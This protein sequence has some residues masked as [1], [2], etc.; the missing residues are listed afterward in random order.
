MI[1]IGRLAHA[2]RADQKIPKPAGETTGREFTCAEQQKCRR[3]A[4]YGQQ[5]E[6]EADKA[7]GS[8]HLSLA[9][10]RLVATGCDFS[11]RPI[12]HGRRDEVL[13]SCPD[14][15]LPVGSAFAR[16]VQDLRILVQISRR[17]VRT[18]T[19]RGS[20]NATTRRGSSAARNAGPAPAAHVRTLLGKRYRLCHNMAQRNRCACGMSLESAC[21]HKKRGIPCPIF[22]F[23]PPVSSFPKARW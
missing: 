16:H 3:D 14:D 23:S 13:S 4:E 22:A 1:A 19:L 15:A 6:D 7:G 8:S 12:R 10:A 18:H 11:R 17:R 5:R 20:S 2:S 9:S 21:S